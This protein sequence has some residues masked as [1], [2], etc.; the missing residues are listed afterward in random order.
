MLTSVGRG[1]VQRLLSHGLATGRLQT[2]PLALIRNPRTTLSACMASSRSLST[3]PA[4]RFPAKKTTAT[5]GR[6]KAKATTKAKAKPKA[7]A[8]AKTKPKAKPKPKKRVKKA[9]TDEQKVAA[10]K[11]SLRAK[12]LLTE[13]KLLPQ[14]PW[15]VYV[16][17]H[18]NDT[19]IDGRS[20]LGERTKA[21]S[22]L[23]KSLSSFETQVRSTY[24]A[25][26]LQIQPL[27]PLLDTRVLTTNAQ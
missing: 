18:A 22:P 2:T 20:G 26:S 13:P 5:P 11:K 19:K 6:P 21:L 10:A 4:T 27:R 14:T 23:F 7:K 15:T 24:P 9:L 25:H 8:K 16:T 12:A 3:S 17:E 1:A